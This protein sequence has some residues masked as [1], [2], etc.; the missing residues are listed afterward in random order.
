[1][2]A[3][4]SW[5][6]RG[7]THLYTGER[8]S[9]RLLRACHVANCLH[10]LIKYIRHALLIFYLSS[11]NYLQSKE[12]ERLNWIDSL[13]RRRA[14]LS[15]SLSEWAPPVC[16]RR[17]ENVGQ[18]Q[19]LVSSIERR[20]RDWLMNGPLHLREEEMPSTFNYRL[21]TA[22]KSASCLRATVLKF[23]KNVLKN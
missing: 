19:H 22:G 14:L 23:L 10:F 17:P 4:A 18:Q 16:V 1:M 12:S 7:V 15:R 21:I 2:R 8:L 3:G 9:S 5:N 13:L 20:F 11:S 6:D